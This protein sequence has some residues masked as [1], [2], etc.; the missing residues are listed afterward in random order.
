[1]VPIP[2]A[3]SLGQ[4]LEVRAA[5]HGAVVA[6]DLDD[7]RGRIETRQPRQITA[8]LGVSGARQ[9]PARLGHQREHVA[10]LHQVPG[11]ASG[12]TAVRIVSARSAAEMP[13]VTPRA[14]SI[15]T[16]KLVV[17]R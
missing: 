10:G 1:M 16:V 2:E 12:A 3:M 14:A 4:P 9:N 8:G 11:L 7:D 13:V 5:R 15:E 17:C 6:Q